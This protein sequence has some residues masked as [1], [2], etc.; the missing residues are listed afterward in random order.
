MKLVFY[1]CA[2]LYAVNTAIAYNWEQHVPDHA[3]QFIPSLDK[4]TSDKNNSSFGPASL[5]GTVSIS[6]H[7]GPL[8]L[9]QAEVTS[10]LDVFGP[11][12]ATRTNFKKGLICHGP[13]TLKGDKNILNGTVQIMGPLVASSM[14]FES[15]VTIFGDMHVQD[16]TFKKPIKIHTSKIEL[17]NTE[18]NDMV[19]NDHQGKPVEIFFDNVIIHGKI[20]IYSGKGIVSLKNCQIPQEKIT[21][22]KILIN[23]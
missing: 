6:A 14:L 21:G 11:L 7:H 12:S 2:Y 4:N 20:T 8:S 13:M 15:P 17:K 16:C 5:N 3:K 9:N 1:I 22:Y 23:N 19:I 10:N 18:I